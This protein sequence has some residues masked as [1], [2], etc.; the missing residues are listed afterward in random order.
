MLA[1]VLE[2]N[3]FHYS[4]FKNNNHI[5]KSIIIVAEFEDYGGMDV[6]SILR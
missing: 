5:I 3:I 2:A 4:D 6:Y 1:E